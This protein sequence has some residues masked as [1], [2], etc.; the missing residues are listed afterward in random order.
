MK[1]TDHVI[2]ECDECR[3]TCQLFSVGGL[4]ID[5]L[6]LVRMVDKVGKFIPGLLMTEIRTVNICILPQSA[7]ES[8]QLYQVELCTA[9]LS[10][11]CESNCLLYNT[12]CNV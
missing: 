11:W 4:S 7:T 12:R 10:T 2:C 6:F 1:V 5:G 3:T 9:I 8:H